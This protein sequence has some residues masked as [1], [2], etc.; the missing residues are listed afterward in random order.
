MLP[1]LSRNIS[2]SIHGAALHAFP[3]TNF[4]SKSQLITECSPSELAFM[5]IA[6]YA[7]TCSS[8]SAG[9]TGTRDQVILFM[10]VYHCFKRN[11][12]WHT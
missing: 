6:G 1:T 8:V 5:L 7:N 3:G 11:S 10:N 4:V 12:D 2:I 9:R